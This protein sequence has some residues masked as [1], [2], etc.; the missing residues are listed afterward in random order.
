MSMLPDLAERSSETEVGSGGSP[1]P[2][3]V[4][5]GGGSNLPLVLIS[6]IDNT[7]AFLSVDESGKP[8]RDHLDFSKSDQ[9]TPNQ[10][11]IGLIKA[12]YSLSENPTIYFVTNRAVGWRDVTVRWLVKYFP[13]SNY[14]W[15]L[16]MRPAN[17]FFS[18]AASIKEGH[19]VDEITKKYSVQQVWEDDPDC[20]LMY[21]SHDLVTMDAKETWPK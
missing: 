11:V 3:P 4:K 14:R 16:R 18:S 1:P 15:T 7:I 8:T 21:R 10:K 9:D 19:L 5:T 17:D 2:P 12:W 6:D 13:P 20:I